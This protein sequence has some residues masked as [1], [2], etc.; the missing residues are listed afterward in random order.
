MVAY[1]VGLSLMRVP[2]AFILGP[3]AGV[4]E[5]VPVVGTTL[6]T[7]GIIVISLLAGYPHVLW[8]AAFVIGWRLVQDYVNSPRIMGKSLEID[9]LA[10]ILAVLAGG[11]SGGD[12]GDLD[13][14]ADGGYVAHCVAA[15]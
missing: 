6:A 3:M 13:L 2:Y 11:R 14:G 15:D 4:L 7:V 8:V 1:T 9:P 12:G 10:Q 5:F